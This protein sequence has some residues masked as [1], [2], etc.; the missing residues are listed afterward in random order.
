MDPGEISAILEW[1]SPQEKVE[2][3]RILGFANFYQRFIFRFSR[4]IAPINSLLQMEKNV[5]WSPEAEVAFKSLKEAFTTALVLAYPVE[6]EPFIVEADAS[7]VAVRAMLSQRAPQRGEC[8]PVAYY[9][10]KFTVSER[11][12]SI[13]DKELLAIKTAFQ[14]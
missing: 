11:N 10:R 7:D 5:V 6:T 3:Q 9:S 8:H 14:E 2:V 4:I 13:F 1:P 12:Y